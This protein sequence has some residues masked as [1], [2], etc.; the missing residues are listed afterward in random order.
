MIEVAINGCNGKMGQVIADTIAASF[1]DQARV[2]YGVDLV[3]SQNGAFPVYASFTRIPTEAHADVMID[4]SNPAALPGLLDYTVSRNI[5]VV[6][7]T[8]GLSREDEQAMRA[9]S[10]KIPVFWSANMSIGICLLKEL[11]KKAAAFL[12]ESY[13]IEIVERH[14][15]RKLDAPSG[16]ALAIADAINASAG[17]KYCYEYDRHSRRAKRKK[18]EIGISSVR[19]GN[20]VGDHEVIF[21]GQNEII[22]INHKAMSR[23]LFADGAVKAAFFLKDKPAGFYGMDSLYKNIG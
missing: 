4:F 2:S 13:D 23:N 10:E 1:A 22:E 3:A 6:I 12:G 5:P 15:N 11:V 8:T 20:I 17:D 21:A 16:T 7:A 19:G 14:H 18:T 9:A